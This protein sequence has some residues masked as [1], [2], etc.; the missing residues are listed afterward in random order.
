MWVTFL[1]ERFI[2]GGDE[3]FE[4]GVVDNDDEYDVLER[5]DKEEAWYDEEEPGWASDGDSPHN[6]G[7]KIE[8]VLEGETGIQDY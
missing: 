1:R 5:R 6:G 2:R 7:R 3:D 4:Y 8:R